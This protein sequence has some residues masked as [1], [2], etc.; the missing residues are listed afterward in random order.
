MKGEVYIDFHI[1][2][3]SSRTWVE[4]NARFIKKLNK[5]NQKKAKF[6][7]KSCTKLSPKRSCRDSLDFYRQFF[8]RHH[9]CVEAINRC[10]VWPTTSFKS[11]WA[12]NCL[13]TLA[14]LFHPDPTAAISVLVDASNNHVGTVFQQHIH[15][16]QRYSTSNF[17][18]YY[19][20]PETCWVEPD[21]DLSRT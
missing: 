3:Y 11:N 4:L 18:L 1:W 9:R 10:L 15:R 17:L 2:G 14:Q 16:R 6:Y 8:T 20:H 12:K 5:L 13:S 19:P 21:F 7:T